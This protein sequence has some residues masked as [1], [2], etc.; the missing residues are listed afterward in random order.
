MQDHR[1]PGRL[2]SQGLEGLGERLAVGG[3][4]TVADVDHERLADSARDHDL[5]PKGAALILAGCAIA[6]VVEP[7]LPDR[8][9]PWMRGEPFEPRRRRV[10]EAAG[11]VGMAP[12]GGVDLR[13]PLGGGD[14]LL[15]ARLVDAD[16]EHAADSHGAR[17][18]D[19][20]GGGRLAE[21]EVAVG[22]DHALAASSFG[23]S[24]SIRSIRAPPCRAPNASS[25]RPPSASASRSLPLVSGM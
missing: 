4:A 11:A 7:G 8:R 18:G 21:A 15:A 13:V 23:N 14:R 24:G 6:V 16:G 19:Q 3:L 5:C 25:S 12:D 2:G 17:V 10:V 22:I 9:H 20:L 1:H